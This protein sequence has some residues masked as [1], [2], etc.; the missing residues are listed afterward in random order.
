MARY[1]SSVKQIPF[2]VES[3]YSKLAD[4][5]NL[6]IIKE[7]INDPLVQQ[8]IPADK[9]DQVRDV[10]DK[11]EFTSDSVLCDAGMVGTVSVEIVE[12]DENKCVKFQ[13]VSSPVPFTFW[14][15]ILPTSDCSSKMKLTVD[16][17][18]NFFMKQMLDKP[19]KSG[20]EKMADMLAMIPYN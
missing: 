3:V 16:A 1:E 19:L 10:I 4:L 17:E 15:Q 2:S 5:N 11:M 14:A 18:L 7:R 20:I 6:Q 9:I 12:R 13:S 8:Q